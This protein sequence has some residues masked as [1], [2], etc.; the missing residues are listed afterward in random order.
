MGRRSG[1]G[2]DSHTQPK[3]GVGSREQECALS[4][5]GVTPL[6]LIKHLQH[7]GLCLAFFVPWSK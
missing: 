6:A 3:G 5:E 1:K 2:G 4:A 7:H